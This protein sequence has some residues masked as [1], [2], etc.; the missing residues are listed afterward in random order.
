MVAPL[1]ILHRCAWFQGHCAPSVTKSWVGSIFSFSFFFID[2][3]DDVLC[4]SKGTDQVRTCCIR[5]MVHGQIPSPAFAIEACPSRP[6]CYRRRRT[7]YTL[8]VHFAPQH[9][10]FTRVHQQPA[11]AR[12][13]TREQHRTR[14]H[15]H[16]RTRATIYTHTCTRAHTHTRTHATSPTHSR[17]KDVYIGCRAHRP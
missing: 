4:G 16:T 3:G 2:D 6:S 13:R 14:A 10:T 8:H 17:F 12:E 9:S 15:A 1:R 5:C 7:S 11:P